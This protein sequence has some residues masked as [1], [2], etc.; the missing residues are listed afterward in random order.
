MTSPPRWW[1]TATSWWNAPCTGT[2]EDGGNCAGGVAGVGNEWYL[3]E[4]ATSAPF[5]TWVLVQNPN[6]AP[7]NIDMDLI[8]GEGVV[9]GPQESIPANSRK[10]YNLLSYVD[11]FDVSTK[12]AADGDGVIVERSM[13]WNDRDG[14]HCESASDHGKFRAYLAE[15]ATAGGFETWVLFQNPGTI[16]ATV[17]VTYLTDEGVVIKDPFVV[18]AGT[19]LSVNLVNDVGEKYDVSTA[20]EA[21]APIVVERAVYWGDA[22]GRQLRQGAVRLVGME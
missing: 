6:A 15:G 18:A 8:T 20:V 2:S 17:Y 12:V 3:A 10:S 16:D 4:G 22:Y 1:R 14:G 13:Y 7:V 21:S 11:T 5:E 9:Q 19:R